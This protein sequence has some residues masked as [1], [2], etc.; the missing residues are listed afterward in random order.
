MTS[1]LTLLP[2]LLL[3]I[4][5]PAV[6]LLLAWMSIKNNSR[7]WF[8]V[9]LLVATVW[10]GLQGLDR[11]LVAQE[12]KAIHEDTSNLISYLDKEIQHASAIEQRMRGD[13][14]A[15]KRFIQYRD[16]IESWRTRTGAEL[17][18]VLPK[19]GAS[20][21]FLAT[22]GQTGLGSLYWEYSQLRSCQGALI[23]ILGAADGFVRRGRSLNGSQ[24]AGQGQDSR[25][26][27]AS[28]ADWS[29]VVQII[30][31]ILTVVFTG[32]LAVFTSKLVEVGRL[33]QTTH[34]ATLDT[35]RVAERAYV[36][37][38]H[39]PP[40]LELSQDRRV[41][42]VEVLIKN[43]GATPATVT[44]VFLTLKIGSDPLPDEPLYEPEAGRPEIAAFLV[45]GGSFQ[46]WIRWPVPEPDSKR[47]EQGATVWLLGY[48][49]Y[50]DTFGRKHRGGY[51]RRYDAKRDSAAVPKEK[52]NN[53]PFETKAGYNYDRPRQ[54]SDG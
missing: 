36:D 25:Q 41:A 11:W 20:Q 40:G 38:S 5:G 52:R 32:Y 43:H 14:K 51:A 8:L 33:Q 23:S 47:I 39:F 2:K 50:E 34:Q 19:T 4:T 44:D 31:S 53:L 30:L 9:A 6:T 17:E 42:E 48:V 28:I 27:G 18:K 1:G 29:G 54:M 21:I 12:D 10:A 16:E 22:L 49:D 13:A 3:D 24:T 7:R 26:R 46:K 35:N 45:A 37:I 15:E